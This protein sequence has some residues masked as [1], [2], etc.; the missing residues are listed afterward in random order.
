MCGGSIRRISSTAFATKL[1]AAL[2]LS[3]LVRV[4][5]EK[6]EGACEHTFML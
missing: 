6:L 1:G 2:E 4:A 3:Q 5:R